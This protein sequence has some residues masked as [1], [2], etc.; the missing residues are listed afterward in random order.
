MVRPRG[1]V[2]GRR[3]TRRNRSQITLKTGFF[4]GLL[5]RLAE[6]TGGKTLAANRALVVANAKLAAQV[7]GGLGA[8]GA[9]SDH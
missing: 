2:N 6:L 8:M 1:E 4:N 3:A 5:G 9:K 7:V